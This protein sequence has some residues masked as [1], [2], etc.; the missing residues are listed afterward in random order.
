[1][2]TPY[3]LGISISCRQTS[4]QDRGEHHVRPGERRRPIEGGLHFGRPTPGRNQLLDALLGPGQPLRVNVHERDGGVLQ[5]REGENVAHQFS[6]KAQA[7]GADKCDLCHVG[8][9]EKFLV[10]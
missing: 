10:S 2:S 6:C 9:S 7:A 4:G 1:M 8:I 3:F 5:E